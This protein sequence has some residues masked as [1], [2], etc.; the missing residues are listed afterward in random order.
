MLRSLNT[1]Y[2]LKTHDVNEST[3]LEAHNLEGETVTILAED[4]EFEVDFYMGEGVR[5]KYIAVGK[6]IDA[7]I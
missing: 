3:N 4:E 1:N 7:N 2:K 6:D 5:E